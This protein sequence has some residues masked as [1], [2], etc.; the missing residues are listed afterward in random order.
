A[1]GAGGDAMVGAG[2]TGGG[3]FCA[4]AGASLPRRVST[5]LNFAGTAI[6][7]PQARATTKKIAMISHNRWWPSLL[8]FGVALMSATGTSPAPASACRRSRSWS[9]LLIRLMAQSAAAL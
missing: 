6:Q 5:A 1:A 4:G 2:A 3:G 8:R 7:P 9:I